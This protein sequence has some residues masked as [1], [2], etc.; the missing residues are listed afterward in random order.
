M[1][2]GFR[3]TECMIGPHS[4]LRSAGARRTGVMK[5]L[6]SAKMLWSSRL[7]A[8]SPSAAQRMVNPCKKPE[9]VSGSRGGR[10]KAF[11]EGHGQITDDREGGNAFNKRETRRDGSRTR[12]N[13]DQ[14]V[15]IQRTYEDASRE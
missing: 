1:K 10:L 6:M 14:R 7:S 5:T 4:A 9:D 12:S 8:G 3:F 15:Q 13:V 11:Y 2:S